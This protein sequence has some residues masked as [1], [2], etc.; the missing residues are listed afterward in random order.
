MFPVWR[1]NG[2][3]YAKELLPAFYSEAT[4]TSVR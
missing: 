2:F 1:K 3:C 4:R